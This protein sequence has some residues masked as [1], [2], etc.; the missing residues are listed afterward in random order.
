M[1]YKKPKERACRKCG[2]TELDCSQCIEKKGY[3]CHWVEWDLC[4]HCVDEPEPAEDIA[5][6]PKRKAA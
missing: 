5:E 1:S 2:C 4:S 3:P 6:T